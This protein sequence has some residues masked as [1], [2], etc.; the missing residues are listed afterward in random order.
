MKDILFDEKIAGSIHFTPGACYDEASNGN[1]SS[2]HWDMVMRQDPEA[3]GGEIWFDDKLVR[4]D[5]RFV[6]KALE[7]LNPENLKSPGHSQATRKRRVTK[8]PASRR[9]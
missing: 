2:I 6:V 8:A 3:G 5:G 9:R 1:K 4:K 7:G